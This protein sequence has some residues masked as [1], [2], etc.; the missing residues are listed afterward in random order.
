MPSCLLYRT[1]KLK[2]FTTIIL[3]VVVYGCETWSVALREKHMLS[4]FEN[5]AMTRIFGTRREE[6]TAD[7]RKRRDFNC[8][9]NMFI[10]MYGKFI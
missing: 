6:V 4:V 8:S 2:V 10:G 3:P 7:R 9:Q 5:S 1:V